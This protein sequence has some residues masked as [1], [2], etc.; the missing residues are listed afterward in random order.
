MNR[1]NFFVDKRPGLIWCKCN[2]I[3]FSVRVESERRL[4]LML[5]TTI[6]WQSSQQQPLK[7]A[8]PKFKWWLL[9]IVWAPHMTS[10]RSEIAPNLLPATVDWVHKHLQHQSHSRRIVS[11]TSHTIDKRDNALIELISDL[12]SRK[13]HNFPHQSA[14]QSKNS[15]LLFRD[16]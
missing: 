3:F 16:Y 1:D 7:Q 11:K 13:G 8:M 12:F 6:I 14:K 10:D 5:I 15:P 2:T 4:L 9:C